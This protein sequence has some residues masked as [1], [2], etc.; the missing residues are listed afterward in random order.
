[1]SWFET[2]IAKDGRPEMI[3]SDV[4]ASKRLS[5]GC[6]GY[7]SNVLERDA[8]LRDMLKARFPD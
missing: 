1:V 8:I 5:A 6:A 7:E 3:I 4:M 2:L